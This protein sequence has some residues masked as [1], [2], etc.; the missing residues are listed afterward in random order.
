MKKRHTREEER[1]HRAAVLLRFAVLIWIALILAIL[2]APEC[3][4]AAETAAAA[5]EIDPTTR[6][7]AMIGAIAVGYRGTMLALKLDEPRR[8]RGYRR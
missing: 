1:L 4:A 7:F 8:K 2:L 3:F 6:R 5:A